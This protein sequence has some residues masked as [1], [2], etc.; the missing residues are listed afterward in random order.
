MRRF[1]LFL[2]IVLGACATY[3]DDLERA[4]AHYHAN[5]Y[6]KAL[7]LLDVL[8]PDLDSLTPTERARYAYYRGM[9]HFRIEQKLHARHW[10][11]FSAASDKANP[12]ALTGEEKK[13]VEETLAEL[14][15]GPWG[16][17]SGK[18]K[19]KG[20]S[21]PAGDDAAPSE[22][23]GGGTPSEGEPEGS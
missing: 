11:A 14:N 12:G 16:E 5:E 10:L 8:E 15:K 20:S 7:A 3:R 19:S 4:T 23:S 21:Q 1:A 13:R 17:S 22:G 2:V 18:A 6:D 9:S